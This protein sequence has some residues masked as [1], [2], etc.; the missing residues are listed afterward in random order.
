MQRSDIEVKAMP[1]RKSSRTIPLTVVA[2]SILLSA[3]FLGGCGG[4]FGSDGLELEPTPAPTAV[5]TPSATATPAPTAT[6]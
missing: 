4:G 5:P 6:P 2:L 3:M 1:G